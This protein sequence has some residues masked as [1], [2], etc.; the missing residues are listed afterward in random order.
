MKQGLHI[1]ENGIKR[2][3]KDGQL[4]RIGGPAVQYPNGK[5]EW[6]QW[7]LLHREDGPRMDLL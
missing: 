5:D 6:Y 2:W 1:N 7:G 4:H 3:Y